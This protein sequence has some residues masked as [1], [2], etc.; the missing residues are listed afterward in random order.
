MVEDMGGSIRLLPSQLGK[1]AT[2]LIKLPIE[3]ME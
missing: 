3:K 1:G 2:F